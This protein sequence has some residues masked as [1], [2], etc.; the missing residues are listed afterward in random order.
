MKFLILLILSLAVVYAGTAHNASEPIS[1]DKCQICQDQCSSCKLKC[2]LFRRNCDDCH[3]QCDRCDEPC[4]QQQQQPETTSCQDKCAI[5]CSHGTKQGCDRCLG[6]CEAEDSG[7]RCVQQCSHFCTKQMGQEVWCEE[8]LNGCRSGQKTNL[9]GIN[10]VRCRA[11]KLGCDFCL[12]Y[13]Q[14]IGKTSSATQ[15]CDSVCSRC[16]SICHEN[17]DQKMCIQQCDQICDKQLG[18]KDKC[19]ECLSKCRDTDQMPSGNALPKCR[20]CKLGCDFCL[21]YTQSVDLECEICDP[22]CSP[23]MSI[24]H[25]ESHQ[26]SDCDENGESNNDSDKNGEDSQ[27]CGN[28]RRICSK[29]GHTKKCTDCIL[30][31]C[32]TG[33]G[34]G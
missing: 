11:C 16:Q 26:S 6:D 9:T 10:P 14:S 15:Q 22:L 19:D 31:N 5:P 2:S 7:D 34:G 21:L 33:T 4:R 20:E 28:C 25:Q 8:C 13:A 17:D 1:G 24:C 23:C 29:F 30:T 27:I 32:G 18:Q 12:I 3:E